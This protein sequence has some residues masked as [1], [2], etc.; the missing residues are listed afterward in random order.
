MFVTAPAAAE[1]VL[2]LGMFAYRPK[3]MLEQSHAAL[4]S[5]LSDSLDGFEVRLHVLTQPE[6][7]EALLR[8]EL[9][10]VFTNP[11]HYIVLRE[12]SALSGAVATLVN[13][14]RGQAVSALGGVVFVRT[15]RDDL[16]D[17]ADLDG[18]LIAITGKQ[19]LGGYTA[20]AMAL[21]RAGLNLQRQR[22]LEVDQPHDNAVE[23]VLEGRAEAG[24]VR[25]GILEEMVAEGKIEPGLFR[26]LGQRELPGFPWAVSGRLYPEWPFV[27]LPHVDPAV[28]RRL[29]SA[30]LALEPGHPAALEAGIHG[31]AIPAD[32][33]PVE[34]A[35]RTLGMAPFDTVPD[36]RLSALWHRYR[37]QVSA[38]VLAVLV[39]LG[40][41]GRL[42]LANRSLRQAR[43]LAEQGRRRVQREHLL[44]QTLLNTLPQVVWLRDDQGR[45]LGCNSRFEALTGLAESELI[46]HKPEETGSPAARDLQAAAGVPNGEVVEAKISFA[47]D[48]HEERLELRTVPMVN[49]EGEFLGTVGVGQDITERV[50]QSDVL[51]A[52]R[53]RLD[54]IISGTRAGTWEW[55][56][57]TGATVFNERWAEIVGYTL[58]ELA[59]VSIATWAALSH[60]Q[61]MARSAELLERHFSGETDHYECEAR[62]K[63]K[64]GHWVWVLDRG[65]VVSRSEDGRPLLVSGTHQDITLR[66]QNEEERRE[67]LHRLQAIAEHVPGFIYQFRQRP[68]GT[69]HIPYASTGIKDIYGVQPEEVANDARLVF[70]R[71]HAED[72]P[73]VAERIG[74]SASKLAP[75][76]DQHRV[77]L[78]DGREIWVEGRS[79][80][81]TQADGSVVWHGYVRDVTAL[82]AQE[83]ELNYIAYYD[84]LTG[85]PNRR[86]LVDRLRQAVARAQ[87][88][89]RQLAVCYL[90]LDGFKQVNDQLGHAAGDALLI[91]TS[92]RL[93][94]T[95]R[96]EDTL[97]RLGGDEFVVLLGELENAAQAEAVVERMQA[98]LSAPVDLNGRPVSVGASFGL[99]LCPPDRPE[100]DILLR[101]ADQ[102]MYRAKSAG[103]N[104]CH[105]FDATSD[106]GAA[107]EREQLQRMGRALAEHEFTLV[108][109]PKV[110]LVDGA[111]QGLEAL[112]RW[113]HPERG[114]LSPGE[115][116]ALADG[117]P[118]ELELGDWVVEQ[119]LSQLED[120]LPRMPQTTVSVNISPRY[121][122]MPDFIDR[123]MAALQR[124]P[125]VHPQALELEI[126]ENAMLSNLDQASA[127]LAQCREHGLRISLDDFGTGYATLSYLRR[128]P[129]D[130]LKIDQSF[131]RGMLEDPNDLGIV[132]SVLR[133]AR[134]FNRPVIAEG[135]ETAEHAATLLQLGCR[136]AQG[137]G[138]GRPMPPEQVDAWLESWRAQGLW[139]DL[140]EMPLAR[141]A[142]FLEVVARSVMSWMND[143]IEAVRCGSGGHAPTLAGQCQ[144]SQWFLGVGA[145]DFGV[146]KEF[147]A[148]SAMHERMHE[149]GEALL[150]SSGTEAEHSMSV[151][152]AEFM[153]AGGT[154]LDALAALAA[155]QG[156]GASG[157][158]STSRY[159]RKAG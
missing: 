37:I 46:G 134:A 155:S 49:A 34:R 15:G 116:L 87:R 61:D 55:N 132:E 68:D 104:R 40:L 81:V 138:I 35:M 7:Q 74:H 95:L 98:E 103:R 122:L 156:A 108:Y 117:S 56:V 86:L 124:H 32:Y 36:V 133:L 113:Q 43:R 153:Q 64:D 136:L 106:E 94:D 135:V 76:L 96:A 111:L 1:Q 42:L 62:M 30:L 14:N 48:G 21:H 97:A 11:A 5:Y 50:R 13:N 82:K 112:L 126:V 33:A 71:I 9:D 19:Y 147:Q 58:E 4:A 144:F 31:F 159:S 115:F 57:Q 107:A 53:R 20:P 119:A 127:T 16:Q 152:M 125:R 120:W 105:V 72:R 41:S 140:P 27:V 90:D 118:L 88:S 39:I 10:F 66:K 52:Q 148:L 63:H 93:Q 131:V 84:T 70:E 54:N 109:Q 18:R 75:W 99:T 67:L 24:F 23:A 130:M 28:A 128:L 2:H 150:R 6:I 151:R 26:V 100:A 139:R 77:Q 8:N 149:L 145:A 78:P 129:V 158:L 60:P 80:P 110:D 123:V 92:R 45:Y 101:H 12:H 22:F 51:A 89:G 137:Y 29:A 44:L 91:E 17:L 142:L 146:L 59:P 157:C 154:L 69:F 102:A 114:L 85:V 73:M 25:T 38:I 83:D 121:L 143:T 65:A 141:E 79:A 47:Q 3:P